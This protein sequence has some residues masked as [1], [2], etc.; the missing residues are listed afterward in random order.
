MVKLFHKKEKI[1][2]PTELARFYDVM[3]ELGIFDYAFYT[4][5]EVGANQDMYYE[6]AKEEFPE[7]S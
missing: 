2:M 3:D 1:T 6:M 4:I 5:E 7:L